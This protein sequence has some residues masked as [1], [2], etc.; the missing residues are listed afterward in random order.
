MRNAI[1][2]AAAITVFATGAQAG[3][4]GSYTGPRGN[5]TSWNTNASN[6]TATGSITGPKGYTTSGTAT[7]HEFPNG[8][9]G[10][11]GSVTGPRG[12]TRSGGAV[13]VPQ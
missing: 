13:F 7:E 5:T 10:V 3:H 8:A 9:Y 1:V 11:T 6:G 4:S 2:L 12:T